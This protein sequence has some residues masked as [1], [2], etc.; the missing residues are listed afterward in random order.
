MAVFFLISFCASIIGAICGIGGGVIIKPVMDMLKLGTISQINFLSCCTVLAMSC[1]SVGKAIVSKERTV[2]LKSGTDL[3]I[4][5]AIG[6]VIGKEILIVLKATYENPNLVGAIQAICLGILTIGTLGY[7]LKKDRIIT[8]HVK[9][10]ISCIIIGLLL[11]ISSSFLG[12]GGGPINLVVLHF[13]FNMGIKKAATNSL[14][15]ILFSQFTSF[16]STIIT[17]TVPEFDSITIAI[18]VIGGITGGIMGRL[19]NKKLNNQSVEKL[20]VGLM[21]L[22]ICIC[23]YNSYYFLQN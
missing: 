3:A 17:S 20:F 21:G 12:I 16:V 4:G 2:D 19:V 9:N 8:L 1:Y 18:M 7:T 11:G 13:F 10:R 14:Y 15:I 6:G 22:I 5:A 23:I